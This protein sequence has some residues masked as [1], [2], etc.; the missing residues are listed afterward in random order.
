MSFMLNIVIIFSVLEDNEDTP[1]PPIKRL[2]MIHP[3][4]MYHTK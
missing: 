3:Q 4:V 2:A 1:M